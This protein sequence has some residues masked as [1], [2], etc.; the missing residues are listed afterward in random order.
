VSGQR[1]R[2]LVVA[3]L[4]REGSRVLVSQRRADQPMP[5]LWEFPGGKVEPGEHPEAALTREVREE[6]GCTVTVDR[7]FEVVFHA[8]PDFD[9]V[10]L[11]YSARIIEGTPRP[12]EVARVEWVEASR[13]PSLD[14]LP[15]DYPLA[16]ALASDDRS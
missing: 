16:E 6:L 12:I 15:A 8:Y 9:L 4:I 5:L 3:A 10:M 2:K 11:V 13:L 7:I 14:L 1:P